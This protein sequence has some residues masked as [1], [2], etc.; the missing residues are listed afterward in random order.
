[1]GA[2][3]LLGLR[4]IDVPASQEEGVEVSHTRGGQV[5]EGVAAGEAPHRQ[6]PPAAGSVSKSLRVLAYSRER[7]LSGDRI[8]T[9]RPLNSRR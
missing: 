5:A 1:M 6:R 2:D 7:K 3:E 4:R 8:R 9:W